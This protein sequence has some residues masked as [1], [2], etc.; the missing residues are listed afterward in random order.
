MATANDP[1]PAVAELL[2]KLDNIV[3]TGPH[4]ADPRV[5]AV[6]LAAALAEYFRSPD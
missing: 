6:K 1:H 3:A 4:E 2:E 5:P